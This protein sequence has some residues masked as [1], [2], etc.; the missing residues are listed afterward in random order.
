MYPPPLFSGHHRLGLLLF[1]HHLG[2]GYRRF[3]LP[4]GKSVITR[5]NPNQ[6]LAGLYRTAGSKTRVDPHPDPKRYGFD[7][8]S[9]GLVLGPAHG[10]SRNDE[11]V[12]PTAATGKQCHQQ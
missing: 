8:R 1:Q 4:G 12:S 5:V 6:H 9:K 10:L 7:Q 2:I 11:Q 3:G